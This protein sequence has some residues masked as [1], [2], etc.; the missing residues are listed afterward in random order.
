[1]IAALLD[2]G[3]EAPALAFRRSN[4]VSERPAPKAPIFRKFR[5][6]MPSQ[7][8]CLPPQIVNMIPPLWSAWLGPS[9]GKMVRGKPGWSVVYAGGSGEQVNWFAGC[10]LLRQECI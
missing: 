10:V 7:K 5:R 8:R 3:A 4:S 2:D 6:E 1:M 9:V